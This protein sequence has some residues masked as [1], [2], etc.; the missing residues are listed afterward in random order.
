MPKL[1]KNIGKIRTI[2]GQDA[3]EGVPGHYTPGPVTQV[4]IPGYFQDNGGYYDTIPAHWE[5]PY[6]TVIDPDWALNNNYYG[7]S[8]PPLG[9]SI[10]PEYRQVL[11]MTGDPVWV[12]EERR[13]YAYEKTWVPEEITYTQGESIWVPPVQAV[14]AIPDITAV[15]D[16]S[17]WNSWARSI[18]PIGDGAFFNFRVSPG[19]R[20]AFCALGLEGF[21]GQPISAFHHAILVDDSGVHIYEKGALILTIKAGYSEITDLRI[22]RQS[23]TAIIYMVVTGGE[24]LIYHSTVNASISTLYGFGYLY[25]GGDSLIASSISDG[26]VQYGQA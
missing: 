5:Y 7:F 1:I 15:S 18:N 8:I 4:I 23:L 9:T 10:Y 16:V 24:S 25:G 19:S 2:P 13:Y 22:I 11:D 17:G 20:G 14:P 26:T 21:V 3:V 12:P 6:K